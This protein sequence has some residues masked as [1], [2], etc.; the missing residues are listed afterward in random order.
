MPVSAQ[1]VPGI[2]PITIQGPTANPETIGGPV[3]VTARH[4]PE[5]EPLGIL[6]VAG[7]FVPAITGTTVYDDNI[8]ASQFTPVGDVSL[9]LRPEFTLR[10]PEGMLSYTATGYGDLVHYM[11]HPSLSNMNAG[12]GLG[13]RQEIARDWVIESRSGA[14]LNHQDPSSFALPVPNSVVNQL[15][16]Y[17]ILSEELSVK[18]RVGRL[19][20]IVTG[21][22]QREDFENVTVNGQ[23]I[24][25]S[26]LN[27]NA[28]SI[29]PRVEYGLTPLTRLFAEGQLLRREYD[30]HILDS[31]GYTVLF[32]SIF[33]W[34]RLTRGTIFTGWRQ[35]FYDDP[36]IGKVGKPSFGVNLAWYPTELAT[37]TLVGKQ[38]FA[39]TP[40]T[41]AT[42]SSAVANIRSLQAEVDYE[43][44]R[45]LVGSGMLGYETVDYGATGRADANRTLGL[46]LNYRLNRNFSLIAQYKFTSRTSNQP[47]FGYDRQQIGVALRSQY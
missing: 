39:D 34:N 25:E 6:T 26:T 23:L 35:R 19:A 38:D 37:F 32:G 12:A 20:L 9:H 33:E 16:K 30:N 44:L 36:N 3:A 29:G 4:Y 40:I 45:Q 2:P 11:G 15:P 22:G 21:G 27:A 1:L 18:Y 42:G 31:T 8:F 13:I 10:S 14:K 7:Q 41:S 46:S 28:W 5:L 47:G 17:T 43:F 24:Q